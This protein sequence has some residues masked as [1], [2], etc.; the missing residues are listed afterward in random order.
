MNKYW[1]KPR[2]YGIGAYPTTWEG[3]VCIVAFVGVEVLISLTF[4]PAA[5][6][7]A[8]F[9]AMACAALMF[10]WLVWIKTDGEWRWRW[11]DDDV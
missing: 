2:R 7:L 5:R 10:I 11:G 1:F 6:P 8:F 4:S 3:L 9:G